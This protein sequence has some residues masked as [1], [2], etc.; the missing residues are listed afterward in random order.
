M[1]GLTKP[2]EAVLNFIALHQGKGHT[3]TI[4]E[5][6][7]AQGYRSHHSTTCVLKALEVK[8]FIT[9]PKATL[10]ASKRRIVLHEREKAMQA[11]F[12]PMREEDTL[13]D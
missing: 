10:R 2:Q 7:E 13:D 1:R 9:R 5:I 11:Q 12:V 8:G 4:R 3:P 6:T